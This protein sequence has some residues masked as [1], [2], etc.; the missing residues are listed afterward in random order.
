MTKTDV[1]RIRRC[2]YYLWALERLVSSGNIDADALAAFGTGFWDV[3]DG[4]GRRQ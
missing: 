2:R 3:V 1:S 4:K